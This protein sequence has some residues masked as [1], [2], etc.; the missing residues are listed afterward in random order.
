MNRAFVR[1]LSLVAVTSAVFLAACG[2]SDLVGKEKL[3]PVKEGVKLADLA[4]I[5]GAGPLTPNQPADSLRLF[6]GYRTQVF[7]AGGKQYRVVW[8]R[9]EPGSIEDEIVRERETPILLVDEAVIGKGWAFF[10]ETATEVGLP[11]PYR[12]S[13]RLDSLAKGQLKTP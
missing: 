8:Y 10:D 2:P 3:E 13:A 6:N 11:N 9:A 12:A 7:L 5:I 1:T 4:P